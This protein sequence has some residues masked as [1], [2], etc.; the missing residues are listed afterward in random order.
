MTAELVAASSL[1]TGRFVPFVLLAY[2][3]WLLWRYPDRRRW[4]VTNPLLGLAMTG[5]VAFVVFLP[6][7]LEFL[8]HPEFFFG[9]ASEVSVFADRVAGEASP[10]QLLAINILRVLGMFSF[11]GDLEWAHG[12]P[13]RPVFDWF[14]AIPFYLGVAWWA[15]R[16]LGKAKP[17]PDPDRDALFLFLA[18]AVMLLAPSVLS[19]AAPNF[20]R[21]LAAAPPVLLGAGLGLTWIATRLSWRAAWRRAL[22]AALIVASGAV[23]F[24]DYFVRY[25]TSVSYTHLLPR[26]RVKRPSKLASLKTVP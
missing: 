18:W 10:W 22:V 5:L 26:P 6:L 25:P 24:Y 9:H 1:P 20:S 13:D 11:D 19:E 17:P 21:T 15:W 2:V 12:I 14:M 4:H 16:L 3:L 7:G 23:T 8:R